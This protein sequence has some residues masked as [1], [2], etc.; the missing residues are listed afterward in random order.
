LGGGP[1]AVLGRDA[2]AGL[3]HRRI[4]V[5]DAMESADVDR[6]AIRGDL[7]TPAVAVALDISDTAV[8]IVSIRTV[9]TILDLF[10][11]RGRQ[12]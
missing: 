8:S 2:G 11:S 1:T 5:L 10:L 3:P 4:R 12:V 7:R 9:P 6:D